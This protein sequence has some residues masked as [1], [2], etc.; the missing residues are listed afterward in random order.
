MNS[1]VRA[2]LLLLLAPSA[3]AQERNQSVAE[4]RTQVTSDTACDHRSYPELEATIHVC[5]DEMTAWYFTIPTATLPP[6]YIRRAM[7]KENNSWIMRTT[8]NWEGE[9]ALQPNF[10]RWAARIANSIGR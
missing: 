6:G 10:D 8:S 1:V 4:I 5:K 2:A 7:V 3:L 9:D